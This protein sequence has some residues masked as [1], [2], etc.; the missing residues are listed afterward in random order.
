MSPADAVVKGG[1]PDKATVRVLAEAGKQ[2]AIYV[3]GGNSAP[4]CL[5]LPT[6]TYKAEWVNTKTGAV[7]KAEK[8]RHEGGPRT[9]VA[10]AYQ[11]DVALRV[12]A[13]GGT[14]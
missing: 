8:F 9:L 12:V 4:L 14:R 1:V 3:R 5:D 11:D 6:G 7:D 10:P 2:Y 13:A